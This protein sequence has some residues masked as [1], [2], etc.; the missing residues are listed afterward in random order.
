MIWR[1]PQLWQT[2]I[3]LTG[4][5]PVAD[6]HE[7]LREAVGDDA[8]AVIERMSEV[9]VGRLSEV[10][11]DATMLHIH[12]FSGE[13]KVQ[14]RMARSD[15]SWVGDAVREVSGGE[16][17]SAR[18][19]WARPGLHLCLGKATSDETGVVMRCVRCL[20]GKRRRQG[21]CGLARGSICASA[22]P[23]AMRLVW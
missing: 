8:I 22:R 19:V 12:A 10:A 11:F 15:S 16:A 23:R 5:G 20:A 18:E 3:V 2:S 9:V 7:F 21:R 14:A 6:P 1:P 17:A 13:R 4:C